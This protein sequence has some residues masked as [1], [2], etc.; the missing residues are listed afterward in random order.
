[1]PLW[2]EFQLYRKK[3]RYFFHFFSLFANLLLLVMPIFSLQIYNRVLSSQSEETLTYLVIITIVLLLVQAGMDYTRQQIQNNLAAVFDN[4]FDKTIVQRCTAL[5]AKNSA[6][7]Q[8]LFKDHTLAKH[9]L[10]S[11]F[12]RSLTD[13][14]WSLVF[15]LVLFFLHPL[16]GGFALLATLILGA[17]SGSLLYLSYQD[18]HHSKKMAARQNIS[19]Q[20]LFGRERQARAQLVSPRIID[21]WKKKND[22]LTDNELD[23]KQLSG[24]G[25]SILKFLRQLVQVGVF[26]VSA[27]LVIEGEIMTGAMLASSILLGRILAPIDQGSSH[28]AAW[29]EAKAAFQRI[30]SLLSANEPSADL[31]LEFDSVTLSI[32]KVALEISPNRFLLKNIGFNLK[33][34][35]CLNVSGPTGSGKSTLL[36]VMANVQTPT[37]GQVLINSV[38]VNKL[39]AQSLSA[40]LCYLPQEPELLNASVAANISGFDQQEGMSQSVLEASKAFDC[41][42]FIARLPH[43]FSTPIGQDGVKLSPVEK[44]KL[45][46]AH[47]YYLQPKLILLDEPTAFLDASSAAILVSYLQQVKQQGATIVLVSSDPRLAGLIDYTV[48][49]KEGA[50]VRAVDHSQQAKEAPKPAIGSFSPQAVKY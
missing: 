29:K 48:E 4:L 16:L 47:C 24:R 6:D 18:A 31:A 38:A 8:N 50:V 13:L 20:Q 2:S 30:D 33:P 21:V 9:Y 42:G 35:H 40:A 44:Q 32:D 11:P 43:G 36:K 37:Q 23:V 19:L 28:Y 7:A 1:M 45:S 26:A 46:L 25:Q 5:A 39:N 15:I 17:V 10:A 3:N 22:A 49:L 27:W 34:G 12:Q 14:P 41:H